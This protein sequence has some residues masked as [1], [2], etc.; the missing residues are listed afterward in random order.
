[1]A[2]VKLK[3]SLANWFSKVGNDGDCDKYDV[4]QIRWSF[5]PNAPKKM[6]KF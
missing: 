3:L 4:L 5:M 6:P 2:H 1:M